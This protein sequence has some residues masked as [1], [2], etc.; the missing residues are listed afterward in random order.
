M[1]MGKK[2]QE[3]GNKSNFLKKE[4]TTVWKNS[5]IYERLAKS[6][7]SYIVITMRGSVW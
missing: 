7:P 4:L 5:I 6:E 1:R 2:K 3:W